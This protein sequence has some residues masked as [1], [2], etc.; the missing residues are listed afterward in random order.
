MII[1]FIFDECNITYKHYI[2]KPMHMVERRLNFVV[3]RDPQ[4]INSLNRSKNHPLIRKYSH[5]LVEKC[6]NKTFDELTDNS[7]DLQGE[8]VKIIIASNIIDIYTRLEVL[9]GLKLSGHTDTLTEVSYLIDELYKSVENQNQ[10][11]YR[12]APNKFPT[13]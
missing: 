11:Q 10:R 7:N 2:K 4:L 13:E 8:G 3:N 1:K 9:L 12:N 6:Q 5:T